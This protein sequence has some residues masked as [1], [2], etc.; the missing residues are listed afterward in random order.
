MCLRQSDGPTPATAFVLE[1]R[2][3]LLDLD[4]LLR[5]EAMVQCI[6]QQRS[7]ADRRRTLGL[8]WTRARGHGGGRPDSDR[9]AET[10][11]N[12]Q[13]VIGPMIW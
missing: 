8:P 10:R 6:N 1:Q 13:G 5:D 11:W 7:G 12:D 9:Q 2:R 4:H 3:L